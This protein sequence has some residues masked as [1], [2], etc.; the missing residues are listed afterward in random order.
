M[1]TS[2][3]A[4]QELVR[5]SSWD[6]ANSPD[7]KGEDDTHIHRCVRLH[8]SKLHRC[9]QGVTCFVVGDSFVVLVQVHVARAEAPVRP[10][11]PC[12][13]AHLLCN[14]QALRVVLD[15]L[16]E[17]SMR[18]VRVAEVPVRP[19]FPRPVAHLLCNR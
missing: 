11:L 17:I 12:P 3:N 18:L 10:D 4:A 15:G 5:A 6:L 2:D 16:A 8:A 14:R 13:V 1:P 9:C 7:V 19:A